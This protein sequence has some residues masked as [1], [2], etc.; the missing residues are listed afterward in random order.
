MNGTI[1]RISGKALRATLSIAALTLLLGGCVEDEAPRI[2][3]IP[4][5]VS[6][7]VR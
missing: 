5:A 3:G 2:S 4:P 1:D 7:K 6:V